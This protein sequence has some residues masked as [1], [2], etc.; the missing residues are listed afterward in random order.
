MN[1]KRFLFLSIFV[2]VLL[3]AVLL[4]A[5]FKDDIIPP[6]SPEYNVVMIVSDALRLDVLGCYG[7]EAK[8]P[9]IDWLAANG[10]LFKNAYSTA[11]V[12]MPSAVSMF[13]G[14]FSR[15]YGVI[16]K[17]RKYGIPQDF[18]FYVNNQEKLAAESLN[19]SG[20]D[21][22][23]DVEN[24]LAQ[25]SNNLQGF[26]SLRDPGKMSR[27]EKKFVL[28]S[29]G[30]SKLQGIYKR[31]YDFLHYLLTVP[32]G[33]RFFLL[34]WIFDPHAP[35]KAPRKFREKIKFDVSKLPKKKNRYLFIG[36]LGM[37]KLNDVERLYMKELYKAE[38]EALDER[39]GY[40]I[41]ALRKRNLLRNTIVVFTSDHGE[42]FGEHG[43]M[44]HSLSYLQPLVNVPLIIMAP[45]LPRNEV[46]DTVVSHLDLMPSLMEL[47]GA[48]FTNKAMGKSYA[49]RIMDKK[50]EPKW[51]YFDRI[52][53]PIPMNNTYK[54]RNCDALIFNWYKIITYNWKGKDYF[55]LY[56]LKKDPSEM[57]DISM[58][59]HKILRK[60]FRKVLRLRKINHSLLL[61]NLRALDKNVDISA[62][63]KKTQDK[64]KSLGYI[65]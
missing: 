38:V 62:E 65:Q 54:K 60:L 61:K 2:F 32:E 45:G 35:Y 51:P 9:H 10:L 31:M 49:A 22:Y 43:R 59:E 27:K 21:V 8:T 24:P 52:S 57:K 12:T 16:K 39:V 37:N 36:D 6:P 64:L 48:K 44:G 3:L 14:N 13:T 19:D 25:R 5:V 56:D 50:S 58:D 46:T 42:L 33:K 18:F 11:P 15:A 28:K 7:G 53:N 1:K 26:K 17:E 40:I 4:F 47:M 34:K 20:Y 30:I 63:W 29:I 55:N 41:K 23:M